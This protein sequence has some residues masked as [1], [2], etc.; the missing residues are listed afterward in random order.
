MCRAQRR[1]HLLRRPCVECLEPRLALSVVAAGDLTVTTAAARPSPASAAAAREIAAELQYA[2]EQLRL[3][4]RG[5][6][7]AVIDSGV[8]YDHPALGG[9]LGPAYRVVGGW[10][11]SEE[12]DADPFDDPPGGFHGTHVAGI[13]GSNDAEFPGIAPDVHLVALRVFNDQGASDFAWIEDALQWVHAHKDDFAY[14]ITT[15]N[16]SLGANVSGDHQA[17]ANRLADEFAQLHRDGIFVAVA[18]GNQFRPNAPRA[19]NYPATDPHVVPVASAGPDGQLSDFSQRNPRVLVAPGEQITSTAPD[20]IDDFNGFTDDFLTA[21]GT[22]SAAPYVAGA[23]VLVR[24]ALQARGSSHID[25]DTI[26][27]ILRDTADRVYDPA[28][29]MTYAHVNLRAALDAALQPSVPSWG[30]VDSRTLTGLVA[31]STGTMYRLAAAHD[32]LFTLQFWPESPSGTVTLE[33]YDAQQQRLAGRISTGDGQRIDLPATAGQTFFVGLHGAHVPTTVQLTNLVCQQGNRLELRGT[34]GNDSLQLIVGQRLE[35]TVNGVSYALDGALPGQVL[36]QAG[37][38][39]DTLR[40]ST[41][42]GNDTA[43]L[44]VGGLKV[45]GPGYVL[46]GYDLEQQYVDGGA[47]W[48]TAYLTDSPGRDLFRGW[49][50]SSVFQGAGFR[51]H[52]QGFADIRAFARQGGADHAQLVGAVASD[53]FQGRPRVSRLSGADFRLFVYGFRSVRGQIPGSGT[54][55]TYVV[56]ARQDPHH[57]AWRQPGAQI[58]TRAVPGTANYEFPVTATAGQQKHAVR[59]RRAPLQNECVVAAADDGLLELPRADTI[60]PAAADLLFCQYG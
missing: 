52:V 35:V 30:V 60:D 46:E 7:V 14:P 22:S 33:V 38:G 32:G 25:Q 23:S 26:E 39:Y 43:T 16:L 37:G 20:F 18:A 47:G 1:A 55:T 36:I 34:D 28:S 24:Q 4:G 21:S 50:T 6:T 49:P 40:L 15:V 44:R 9:G 5:Q 48:N 17:A 41:G 45:D 54:K 11:F 31:E 3:T 19:L 13:L 53:T 51:H 57:A 12:R 2:H 8:A 59:S 10:D 29:R 27:Q 42:A 58:Q 56:D